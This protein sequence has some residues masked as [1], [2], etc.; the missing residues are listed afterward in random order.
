MRLHS[1]ASFYKANPPLGV[2]GV[3]GALPVAVLA[4]AD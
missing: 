1:L 3:G 4:R 2:G